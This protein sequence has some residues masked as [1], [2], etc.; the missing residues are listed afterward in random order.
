MEKAGWCLPIS[1]I[2]HSGKTRFLFVLGYHS[3]DHVLPFPLGTTKEE[4]REKIKEP[5]PCHL[6]TLWSS[7]E[8]K[9][10]TDSLA[11]AP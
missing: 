8:W 1:P 6:C 7:A 2:N 9:P 4:L 5:L 10:G 3:H 11:D